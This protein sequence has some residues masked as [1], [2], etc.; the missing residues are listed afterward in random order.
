MNERNPEI[1][2]KANATEK[3]IFFLRNK[4]EILKLK[5][6]N[7][8]ISI[9]KL[10]RDYLKIKTEILE[11]KHGMIVSQYSSIV[12]YS[13]QQTQDLTQHILVKEGN[14]A[15]L[16]EEKNTSAQVAR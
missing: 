10:L 13:L 11:K 2:N 5:M 6:K 1:A 8:K 14:L 12:L 3:K 7:L 4:S 16:L 15:V 9:K